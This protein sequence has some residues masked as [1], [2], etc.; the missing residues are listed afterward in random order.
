MDQTIKSLSSYKDDL[1]MCS[2]VDL[3]NIGNIVIYPFVKNHL[4]FI[5]PS[6]NTSLVIKFKIHLDMICPC[7]HVLNFRM[8]KVS[9]PF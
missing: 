1:L 2:T 5:P 8:H 9:T 7:L 6:M 4:F 3:W